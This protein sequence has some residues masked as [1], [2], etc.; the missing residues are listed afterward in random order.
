MSLKLDWQ[1]GDDDDGPPER[2]RGSWPV[3][4]LLAIAV[5]IAVI[6]ILFGIWSAGRYETAQVERRLKEAIQQALD[7]ERQAFL[8]GDGDLFFDAQDRDPAWLSAQLLPENQIVY[9]AGMTITEIELN[10]EDIWINVSWSIEG[11][12][13]QRVAFFR[14]RR[15]RLIH[16]ATSENFWGSVSIAKQPWGVLRYHDQD[17]RWLWEMAAFIDEVVDEICGPRIPGTCRSEK[18]PFT[19]TIAGDYRKTAAPNQLR[20]PSPR[21]LALDQDG[22]PADLYWNRLRQEIQ[23]YLTPA[24]IRFAVPDNLVRIYRPVAQKYMSE[25]KDIVVE[26]VSL[27]DLPDDPLQWPVDIDGAALTPNEEMLASGFVYDLTDFVESDLSF[28]QGDFYEQIWQGAQW[29]DRMWFV[30]QTASMRL[31]Y[32]DTVAYRQAGLEQPSL[33]WTWE[34]MSRDMVALGNS[35]PPIRDAKQQVVF[36]DAGLDTLFAFAYTHNSDCAESGI[37]NCGGLRTGD[38]AAALE[39]YRSLIVQPGMLPDLTGLSPSE[40]DRAL[41]NYQAALI[42]DRPVIYENRLLMYSIGAVPFP[43]SERFDGITPLWVD[44]SFIRQESARPL[45]VWDWLKFLSYQLLQ[46]GRRLVPSRP[47]VASSTGFW[48]TLPQSLGDVMRTA[49]PFAKPFS[50]ED[51][52]LLSW[53]QLAVVVSGRQT[54]VEAAQTAPRLNWFQST[55]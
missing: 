21:L 37:T 15:D 49:F 55:P 12:H 13:L 29:R 9:Q 16:M 6:G 48:V 8:D 47:S 25:G 17:R 18:F 45:A 26:I 20:L 7:L 38:V 34:E 43:G 44:G 22:N 23:A 32:Y 4:S 11:E 52:R 10:G 30:P 14:Q 31:I 41:L 50:F 39:W 1:I 33:R 54:P 24:V 53:D 19:L 5:T 40:R 46:P 2:K 42:V 36:L 51:Q 3:T 35:L 28:N 27:A